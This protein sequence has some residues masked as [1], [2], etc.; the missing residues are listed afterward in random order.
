MSQGLGW[1]GSR[2]EASSAEAPAAV[3]LPSMGANGASVMGR[4]V[5]MKALLI[6]D[7]AV[8]SEHFTGVFPAHTGVVGRKMVLSGGS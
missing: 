5:A 8:M 1:A 7:G 4:V 2:L 6:Q 3:W